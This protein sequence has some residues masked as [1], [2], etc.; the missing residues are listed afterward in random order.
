M[1]PYFYH[2]YDFDWVTL[3]RENEVYDEYAVPRLGTEYN[4]NPH[5]GMLTETSSSNALELNVYGLASDTA[6]ALVLNGTGTPSYA[7][8]TNPSGSVLIPALQTMELPS[9][10]LPVLTARQ[11]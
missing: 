1:V 3:I 9:R 5:T 2:D 8:I 4:V 6:W 10:G 7:G 11:T